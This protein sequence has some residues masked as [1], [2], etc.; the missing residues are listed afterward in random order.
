MHRHRS[1]GCQEASLMS[2]S[3]AAPS[4]QSIC[5]EHAFSEMFSKL[6]YR[7]ELASLGPSEK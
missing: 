4:G 1:R 6:S 5:W 7:S 2:Q 3:F